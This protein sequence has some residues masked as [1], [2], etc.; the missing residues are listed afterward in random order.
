MPK[1]NLHSEPDRW[2]VPTALKERM[3]L[4]ARDL[5]SAPTPAEDRLW[6]AVRRRQLD[7]RRFRR[8][9]AIGPFIVDFYCPEERLAVEV[10]GPVHDRKPEEDRVRQELIESLGIRFVR[11]TND[12]VE[13]DMPAVLDTIRR[14]F[15]AG[16]EPP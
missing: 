5:R 12:Q 2:H 11:V 3:R 7:G 14:A 4:A 1:P 6:Q 13:G 8:Q 10:D 16:S 15:A 9:V